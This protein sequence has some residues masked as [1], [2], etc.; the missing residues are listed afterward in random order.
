V[1]SDSEESDSDLSDVAEV[2]SD[3]EREKL[4]SYERPV[5]KEDVT[6]LQKKAKTETPSLGIKKLPA[7]QDGLQLHFVHG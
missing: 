2:D 7:P 5:Y 6:A 4:K 3:V 1:A